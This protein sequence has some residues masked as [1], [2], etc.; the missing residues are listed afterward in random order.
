MK[1][2]ITNHNNNN[3]RKQINIKYTLQIKFV[4]TL[5]Y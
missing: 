2:A 4:I 3:V 5:R 1:Y